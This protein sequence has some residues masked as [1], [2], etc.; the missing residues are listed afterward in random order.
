MIKKWKETEKISFNDWFILPSISKML[1][2]YVVNIRT[3]N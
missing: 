1:F 3:F 2:Q